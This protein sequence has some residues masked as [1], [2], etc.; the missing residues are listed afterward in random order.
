MRQLGR[1]FICHVCALSEGESVSHGRRRL[2]LA[3]LFVFVALSIDGGPV[4]SSKLDRM[5]GLCQRARLIAPPPRWSE[6][7]RTQA[8]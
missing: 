4:F 3:P 2:Y 8:P 7:G 6:L 1:I 5:H